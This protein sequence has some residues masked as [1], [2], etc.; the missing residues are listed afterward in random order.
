MKFIDN[1]AF[2]NDSNLLND[3]MPSHLS[4][5]VSLYQSTDKMY[6]LIE[7]KY[8]LNLL[9]ECQGETTEEIT[10]FANMILQTA[11]TIRNHCQILDNE[12][13]VVRAICI[14]D[15][16]SPQNFVLND[17]LKCDGNDCVL[18]QDVIH[19]SW[20]IYIDGIQL[21]C[22][23][24]ETNAR[25]VFEYVKRDIRQSSDK[26]CSIIDGNPSRF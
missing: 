2:P 15:N 12:R 4:E 25:R 21:H 24:H 10:A 20:A 3:F 17:A 18:Y 13:A 11:N 14:R 6:L 1:I 26:W 9:Y 7:I 8:M 23:R 22:F 16:V 5:N 19:N